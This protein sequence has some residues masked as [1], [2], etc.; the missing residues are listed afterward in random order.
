MKRTV[1]L[2]IAFSVLIVG[3]SDEQ[4]TLIRQFWAQKL[5]IAAPVTIPLTEE[6]D[7]LTEEESVPEQ[8]V[9]AP[10]PTPKKNR[11][12]AASSLAIEVKEEA[13]PAYLF[14]SD[15]CPWCRKLKQQGFAAKFK[16]KHETDVNLKEYEVS[17][18]SEGMREYSKMIRKYKLQGGVPLMIVGD[19]VLQGYSD[20]MLSRADEALQKELKKLNRTSGASG[21]TSSLPAVLSITMDDEDIKTVAPQADKQQIKRYL[22]RVQ[23]DNGEML[24][25]MGQMFSPAV[26]NQAM[27][28]ASTYEQ[29]LKDLAAKSRSYKAFESAAQKIEAEQ[30]QQ[31]DKLV[32]LNIKHIRK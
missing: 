32:L 8:E 29:K 17:N 27:L 7:I 12:K 14:L 5:G 11:K 6:E 1:F 16:R 13:I 22:N 4:R 9:S 25:S 3:C 24:N 31:I 30:Q 18:S 23:E 15:T 28:I 2:F 19:T 21:A 10:A 26:R 20:D